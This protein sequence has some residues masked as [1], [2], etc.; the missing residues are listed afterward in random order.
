MICIVIR[1]YNVDGLYDYSSYP[2]RQGRNPVQ[3]G[4]AA[5]SERA[6]QQTDEF[7]AAV[8]QASAPRNPTVDSSNRQQSHPPT[9]LF[10]G[11]DMSLMDKEVIFDGLKNLYR[12]KVH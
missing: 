1:H 12:K 9:D 4:P 5:G 3:A 8:G 6:F 10:F 2:P 7:A 11:E